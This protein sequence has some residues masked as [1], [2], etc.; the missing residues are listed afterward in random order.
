M[1]KM[2]RRF[3]L[4]G[5]LGLAVVV[6][7]LA[8]CKTLPPGSVT[9]QVNLSVQNEVPPVNSPAIGEGLVTISP[10]HS[11]TAKISVSNMTA[12]AAHIHE[13]ATGTN[14]PVIVPFNKTADNTFEAPDGA[15]LTD[16]Q[17]EAYK[18]GNLYVNVHSAKYPGGELRA[19]LKPR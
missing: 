10:D 3:S 17:Y 11:V 2:S 19:Q 7:I 13:G 18:A 5:A 9:Y 1:K 4:L 8:G 12:T 15:K 14:G 6:G 16:A